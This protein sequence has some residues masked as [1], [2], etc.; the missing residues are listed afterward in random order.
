MSRTS[1]TILPTLRLRSAHDGHDIQELGERAELMVLDSENYP[2]LD[3]DMSGKPK[4]DSAR[5]EIE[6][7]LDALADGD[8]LAEALG[9]DGLFEGLLAETRSTYLDENYDGYADVKSGKRRVDDPKTGTAWGARTFKTHVQL[10]LTSY[11]R[12]GV[13]WGNKSD[14]ARFAYSPLP[15]VQYERGPAAPGYPGGSM[16]EVHGRNDR[17]SGR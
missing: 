5:Q 8:S 3:A 17:Q 7:V 15:Q 13:T 11:T 2:G 4:D 12:F 9:E 14:V 1:T 10:G 16:G 6:A